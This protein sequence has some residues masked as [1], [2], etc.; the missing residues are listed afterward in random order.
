MTVIPETETVLPFATF[1]SANVGVALDRTSVSP[2]NLLLDSVTDAV[3]VAS[4][5]LFTPAADTVS[6]AC[7]MFA[8]VDVV[9]LAT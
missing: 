3:V 5:V 8:V 9:V 2:E 4:Y 6:E 7:V 1:L